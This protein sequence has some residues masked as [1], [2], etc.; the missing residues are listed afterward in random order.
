MQEKGNQILEKKIWAKWESGLT[1]VQLKWDSPVWAI[2]YNFLHW[3][4]SSLY[5]K[6]GSFCDTSNA[7]S[8]TYNMMFTAHT[9]FHIINVD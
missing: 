9:Y 2:P 6:I 5:R 3:L 4:P 8:S 1:T 7:L